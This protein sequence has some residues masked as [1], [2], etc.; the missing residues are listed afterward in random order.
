MVDNLCMLWD[1]LSR[2]LWAETDELCFVTVKLFTLHCIFRL[3]PH[4]NMPQPHQAFSKRGQVANSAYFRIQPESINAC[5]PKSTD[6]TNRQE[7][8]LV[9]FSGIYGTS[10]MKVEADIN[11]FIPEGSY[12]LDW[13]AVLQDN[14]DQTGTEVNLYWV[15]DGSVVCSLFASCRRPFPI[16]D[17]CTECSCSCFCFNQ[18]VRINVG[19]NLLGTNCVHAEAS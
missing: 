13:F 12:L 2:D 10:Q 19:Q 5:C 3:S 6:L 11:D 9:L 1:F 16:Q 8:H 15:N 4:F 18:L 14:F 17:P 7:K